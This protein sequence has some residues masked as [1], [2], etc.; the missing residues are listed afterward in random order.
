[1]EGKQQ[2]VT[3]LN[4]IYRRWKD[5]LSSLSED[6][7][8]TPLQPSTWTVKDVVAHLWAWQQGSVA[9][10]EAALENREPHYPEWWKVNGPNPEAN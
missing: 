5:L 3:G 4:D 7:I 6:Q 2:I 8:L 1:M 9:R 10:M